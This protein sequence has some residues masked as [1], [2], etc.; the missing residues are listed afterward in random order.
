MQDIE[1]PGRSE[2]ILI[3][4][5]DYLVAERLR[6]NLEDM[7]YTVVGETA[8]GREVV[9][10]TEA[11][12]P[13][14]VMM[15][16]RLLEA[17]GITAARRITERCPTPVVM[18]T[19]HE[20][21]ELV[22]QAGE[23]GIGYYLL[24]P[25]GLREL[26]RAMRIAMARFEDMQELRRLNAE[27]QASERRYALAQRAANIGSW[28]W[29]VTTGTLHWS[30]RIEPLFGFEPGGFAGTYAAFLECVHPEDRSL[31]QDAVNTCLEARGDYNLEHRIIWPDGTV[32]WLA[33]IGDVLRSE[34][35]APLRMM[36]IVQDVTARK[37]AETNLQRYA[38]ALEASNQEL[39]HFAYVVSH[40]LRE[41]LRMV[42]SYLGLLQRRYREQLDDKADEFIYYAVDGA[43]RMERLI[44][45]LLSYAR[46]ETRGRDPVPTDAEEVLGRVLHTLQFKCAACGAEVT[47]DP[48]PS[49]MADPTQLEQLFQ[50]LIGNALK[51]QCE[52]QPPRV[53][54]AVEEQGEVWRFA[55]QDNGIGIP[56]DQICR[57]F[58]IFQRLYTREEYEGTG[59]G[60]AIC[61]KIVERHGGR[62][63]VESEV[64][65]GSTFYFTLPVA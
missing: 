57:L 42:K 29:D 31:V 40:D 37:E 38:S 7:G 19:A 21:P 48:L 9:E 64:G 62:I 61:K 41:P 65:E 63:W 32:R 51:F 22:A 24:K 35:G 27:V 17:S 26:E 47:H 44:K 5:D 6:A 34:D 50:N 56:C 4:E 54:I 55:V 8:S 49:V 58:Q 39:Q 46:V 12:R 15:D 60:L 53:H 28:D 25:A 36:G 1:D 18:L 43:E 13:D 11:L 23:A 3:A 20:T 2:R 16:F 30:D 14:V 45:D 33:E 59:I 52:G 10:M